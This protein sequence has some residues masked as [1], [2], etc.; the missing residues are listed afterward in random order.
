MYSYGMFGNAAG[1]AQA[2]RNHGAVLGNIIKSAQD[3]IG[4]YVRFSSE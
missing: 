1:T 2:D 3:R 4:S